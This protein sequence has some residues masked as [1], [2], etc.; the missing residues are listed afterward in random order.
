MPEKMLIFTHQCGLVVG[1]G[2]PETK[3]V[4]PGTPLI[5]I[6]TEGDQ[7]ITEGNRQTSTKAD[8]Q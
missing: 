6:P 8:K 3:G 7:R 5:T 2:I 4:R 1:T